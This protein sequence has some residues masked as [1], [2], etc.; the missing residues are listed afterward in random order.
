MGQSSG[1]EFWVYFTSPHPRDMSD[2]VLE[3][4]AK[5]DCLA[6]QIHLAPAVG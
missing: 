3:V 1:K 2:E 4:I 5:Y 6:K